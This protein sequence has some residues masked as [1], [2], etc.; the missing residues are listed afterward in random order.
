VTEKD[1]IKDIITELKLLR[2]A[3]EGLN[4]DP[5]IAI[6]AYQAERQ[7]ALAATKTLAVSTRRLMSA[8]W[9]LVGVTILLAIA[10]FGPTVGVFRG[11]QDDWVLYKHGAGAVGHFK[12]FADCQEASKRQSSFTAECYPRAVNPR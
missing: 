2:I 3:I 9:A 1:Q 10:A 8:T 6:A 5:K 11:P 4:P 12:T 7:T